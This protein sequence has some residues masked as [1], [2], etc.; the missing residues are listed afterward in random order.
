MYRTRL[1]QEVIYGHFREFMEVA[2]ALQGLMR[3]RGWAAGTLWTPTAG[4]SNLVI[5]ETEYPDL[6]SFQRESEALY[7]DKE[8][9]DV[10]RQLSQHVVQGSV[11]S[12]L[13][14]AAP[15]LA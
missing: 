11:H 3:E 4:Q 2:G 14:E 10:V 7:S 9:M 15:I 5:W 1:H 12:E 8:A 6:A 13:L